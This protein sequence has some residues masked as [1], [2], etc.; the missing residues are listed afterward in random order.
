ME[1]GPA[2]KDGAVRAHAAPSVSAAADAPLTASR[3]SNP[4]RPPR[5]LLRRRR[6][7]RYVLWHLERIALQTRVVI[8]AQAGIQD[9]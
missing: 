8:P 2:E 5:Y 9:S 7:G 4:P 1:S 6:Q 3:R